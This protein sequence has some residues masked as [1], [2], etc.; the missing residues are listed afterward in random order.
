MDPNAA[1]ARLR[2]LSVEINKDG[3]DYDLIAEMSTVFDGL[4]Q[5][6][7]RGGFLPT[8]WQI[9]TSSSP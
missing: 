6:L 9:K 4:D 5:W 8:A 2:E 1:L 7:S 3:G